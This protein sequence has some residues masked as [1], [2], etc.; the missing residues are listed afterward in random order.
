MAFLPAQIPNN[1]IPIQH[2]GISNEN[3]QE[4]E[5]FKVE[6]ENG[7]TFVRLIHHTLIEILRRYLQAE[8]LYERHPKI[9]AHQLFLILPDLKKA[10]GKD[11]NQENKT[12]NTQHPEIY[13]GYDN[14]GYEL[15]Y[16]VHNNNKYLKSLVEFIE[17]EYESRV[18][19]IKEM[20]DNN[21]ISFKNLFYLFT[22]GQHV[23]AVW[24]ECIIGAKITKVTYHRTLFGEYMNIIT[25]IIDSDG[26]TF[27][28]TSKTFFISDWE[29]V[30]EIEKLPVVPLPKESP[31]RDNLVARGRKFV[32]YAIGPH[33]LQYSGN[34]FCNIWYGI[35]NFKSD[36]RVMIDAVSFSKVNPGYNMIKSTNAQNNYG[37]YYAQQQVPMQQHDNGKSVKEEELFMCAPSLYGFSFTTK[38]WGQL[39]VEELDEIKFDDDA[40]DQLVMDPI[41]KELISSLVTSKHKGVDLIS[42]KGGG[43]V[44]LLHGPPGVGK[45]LTAEAISEFLHRPLYAVSVG[46]LGTSAV[47][48][49][50]KLS[51]ILEVASI[52]NAV[53]LIDEADIFL[54]RRS[55]HDIHRNA[56][57][58]VFLRLLEYHQG[59]LFLTT[60]RV[61]CFDA[62]FQ[63]RISIALKYNELDADARKQVWRTFLDRIDG[64]NKSQ[65]DIEN[66]KKRPLNG[67]EI[68]TAVRLAKALTTKNDPDALITTQQLETIL[69][70]S[71]SFGEELENRDKD[72]KI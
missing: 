68:K 29:G 20:I 19:N 56:L 69:D 58:S 55:E 49:E 17:K 38:K 13:N 61:K 41:K 37:L 53:I 50:N 30:R 66:L 47:D 22:K 46:E 33:Y 8:S 35:T 10:I 27:I 2:P 3:T 62:A 70:I 16:G 54:E 48:L 67:R 39:Y 72:E 9:P 63:S 15:P 71:K 23:R 59:I 51:E 11:S 44:F 43:C 12:E 14:F 45:T 36:G 7:D 21:V 6:H 4:T 34:M 26:V 18:C 25:E 60:N 31:I 1:I 32:K 42:G 5:P 24:N 65:V 28:H 40:F 57:V 52:W 64:K